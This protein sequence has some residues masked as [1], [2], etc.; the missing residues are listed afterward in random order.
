MNL[1]ESGDLKQTFQ[2][3]FSALFVLS[4]V[5][6]IVNV[7]PFLWRRLSFLFIMKQNVVLLKS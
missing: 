1:V 7:L 3:C 6:G 5:E 4:F 2:L